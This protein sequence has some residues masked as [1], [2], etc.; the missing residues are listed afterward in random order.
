MNQQ[1][2]AEFD[3]VTDDLANRDDVRAV[4]IGAA[5]RA[6]SVGGDLA[7]FSQFGDQSSQAM[8]NLADGLHRSLQRLATS[9]VPIVAAVNGI[10]AGSGMGLACIAD[11]VLASEK[12]RFTM[13]YT[14]VGLSPDGGSTWTLPRIVGVKRAVEL[15]LTNRI[16]GAVEAERIGLVNRVVVPDVLHSEA[17]TVARTLMAGSA[18]AIAAVKRLVREAA[19]ADFGAQLD[20]EAATIASLVAAP[21]G[22]EGIAAFLEQRRPNFER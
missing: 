18:K 17:E 10:A 12:A 8:R 19:G 2:I 20:R 15:M 4:L 16:I 3:A 14:G 6:F 7:A 9:P 13:A 22:R 1:F 5:G 11:I 21:D